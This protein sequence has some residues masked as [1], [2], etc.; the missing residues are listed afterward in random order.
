[1]KILKILV[2]ILL[3]ILSHA[4][5]R[6]APPQTRPIF[7]NNNTLS[8]TTNKT[9]LPTVV[10][11]PRKEKTPFTLK[12]HY[13]SIISRF[14][15]QSVIAGAAPVHSTPT[16]WLIVEGLIPINNPKVYFYTQLR[17]TVPLAYTA[18]EIADILP[19]RNMEQTR[20]GALVGIGGYLIDHRNNNGIGWS[21]TM[22]GGIVIDGGIYN[23]NATQQRP[24]LNIN[25][26]I[27]SRFLNIGAEVN[28]RFAYSFHKYA[29]L[30][31]GF[32][33]GYLYAIDTGDPFYSGLQTSLASYQTL[34]FSGSIGFTF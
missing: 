3:P 26:S 30:V 6:T 21:A 2:L 10:E 22:N 25:Q 5:F 12:P 34:N 1:M 17:L 23:P 16:T 9:N 20:L 13:A 4:Q 19:I 11:K 15:V 14:G 8:T 29:G 7:T 32:D 24:L 33:I 18:S 31:M 28:V 27:G